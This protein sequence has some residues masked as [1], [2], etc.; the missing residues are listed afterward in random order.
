MKVCCY[1]LYNNRKKF[2]IKC[3][4]KLT[5]STNKNLIEKLP[6]DIIQY[7][8]KLYLK[9]KNM[10]FYSNL[11]LVSKSF[12]YNFNILYKYFQYFSF[13]NLNNLKKN[14]Y[15]V[16]SNKFKIKFAKLYFCSGRNRFNLLFGE[17]NMELSKHKSYSLENTSYKMYNLLYF[18]IIF[19][20]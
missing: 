14:I 1:N 11:S 19:I 5:N 15:F 18:N 17:E 20:K 8:L 12:S 6:N 4:K 9:S 10:F 13:N 7:I 2:C 3:K 16:T